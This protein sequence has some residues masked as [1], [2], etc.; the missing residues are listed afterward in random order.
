MFLKKQAKLD[1]DKK[2]KFQYHEGQ[3]IPKASCGKEATKDDLAKM[4][5]D[6]AQKTEGDK[7]TDGSSGFLFDCA[8]EAEKAEAAKK[9]DAATGDGAKTL[10]MTIAVTAAIA[11]TM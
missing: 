7:M 6:P 9:D 8:S 5:I 11:Y 10:A 2:A 4:E 3:C 1:A